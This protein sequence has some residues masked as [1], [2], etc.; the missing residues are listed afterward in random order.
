MQLQDKEIILTFNICVA[1]ECTFESKLL[2]YFILFF[3]N[4]VNLI[5]ITFC[6]IYR[7]AHVPCPHT[8][9]NL[10]EVLIEC[11]L[12]W[13]LDRKLSTLTVDNCNTNDSII[14][15]VLGKLDWGNLILKG[16]YFHMRC[17]AH[18]LN[19]I[20]KDGM[21]VIGDQIEKIR[22]SVAFWR[23]TPKREERFEEACRQL[24]ITYSK[25]LIIDCKTR[26]N[27]TYLMLQTALLYRDVF[28]RLKQRESSYKCLPSFDEW[29]LAKDMCERLGL[30]YNVTELFSGRRYPTA[31]LYFPKL[32]EIKWTLSRWIEDP[33]ESV[34]KMA[35]KMLYKFDKYWLVIHGMM[36]VAAMLDPRFKQRI[37]DV[38]KGEEVE[39]LK[40][41]CLDMFLE[42]EKK[43][44]C[45]MRNSGG[46]LLNSSAVCVSSTSVG[47][48]NIVR[49]DDIFTQCL[50]PE[51]LLDSGKSEL[52][53]YFE[54]RLHP[55]IAG[56]DI[57]DWWKTNG[58][59][60]PIVSK[61]A[62][63]IL[64]IP[65]TTVASES[66]FSASGRILDPYCS[67]LSPK[68]MESLMCG[69][70]W[71]WSELVDEGTQFLFPS[72]FRLSIVYV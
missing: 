5:L 23:L 22:D 54:E 24:E 15:L 17:C 49:F 35:E 43:Y 69:K 50:Q 62:R 64:A 57:L 29:E 42:Y 56:F 67:R 16:E 21:D 70:S 39:K 14:N 31:N 44:S 10:C 38:Y 65:I 46:S 11:F 20:V 41:I 18:I 2:D 32:M 3:I 47:S 27:S 28:P 61:M 34:K 66:A 59:K 40:G 45:E 48:A 6:T 36:G 72:G 1:H 30:F 68:F 13:N 37:F 8:A 25:K 52:D 71:L 63:D 12:D 9:E 55:M 33:E 26:W 7:F 60:Y 51:S 19:L 4:F 53:L 58:S